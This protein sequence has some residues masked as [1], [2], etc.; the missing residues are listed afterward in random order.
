MKNT[1]IY[2]SIL[3]LLFSC[4]SK[5][6]SSFKVENDWSKE[7]LKGK[8]A[9]LLVNS[10]HAVEKDGKIKPAGFGSRPSYLTD[11]LY[12]FDKNG[13]CVEEIWYYPKREDAKFKHKHDEN[14]RI[15]KLLGFKP[16]NKAS[17]SIDYIYDENG[18][19]I[20]TRRLRSNGKLDDFW[21]EKYDE[22]GYKTERIDYESDSTVEAKYNYKNDTSGNVLEK[23]KILQDNTIGYRT[24]YKYNNRNLKTELKEYS[25]RNL[26]R[27]RT[28]RTYEYNDNDLVVKEVWNS[29]YSDKTVWTFDYEFD[30][31]GNWIKQI[32]YKNDEP[33]YIVGRT[34][35]YYK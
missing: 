11:R 5:N 35:G 24:T 23:T 4:T 28:T 22:N 19:N 29:I 12:S 17:F 20:E 18:N 30:E 7:N 6:K 16:V 32:Q 3:I 27:P 33:K 13:Y 26:D 21:K 31:H 15:I 1:L 8:V 9:T 10:F 34:I 25:S 14:G 2:T